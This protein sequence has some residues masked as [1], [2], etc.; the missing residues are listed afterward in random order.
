MLRPRRLTCH[1]LVRVTCERQQSLRQ[2]GDPGDEEPVIGLEHGFGCPHGVALEHRTGE[3]HGL[4]ARD[5][6]AGADL[7]EQPG[8]QR[9]Q[10]V[11]DRFRT[12]PNRPYFLQNYT[13]F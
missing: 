2:L 1:R 4:A 5:R 7:A 8:G 13:S 3:P 9:V 10:T 12:R 11:P 6:R